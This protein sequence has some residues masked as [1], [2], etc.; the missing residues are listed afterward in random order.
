[1][2][3]LVVCAIGDVAPGEV[4]A[5]TVETEHGPHAFAVVHSASDHW[6]TMDNRCSHGRFKLSEGFVEDETIECTRH[7]SVFDLLTGE[8]LNPPASSPI[9]TYPTRTE[10]DAVVIDF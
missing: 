5:F 9:T 3:D 6:F 8:S 7:G 10:G 2:S 1:M 4:E